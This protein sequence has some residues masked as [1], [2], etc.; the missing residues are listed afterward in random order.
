MATNKRVNTAT[1]IRGEVYTLRHP[2]NTAQSPKESL[3]FE[4]GVPVVIDDNRIL[5]ILENL[6]DEVTDGEGEIYE[7]PRFRVERGVSVPEP[8]NFKKPTR[9]AADRTTKRRPR[10]RA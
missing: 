10:R 5:T 8:D 6:I 9:L 7:K 1:L 4:Y 2:D 3:R